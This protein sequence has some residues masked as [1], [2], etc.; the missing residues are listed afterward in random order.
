MGIPV[1]DILDIAN[2][3][4]EHLGRFHWTDIASDLQ[5]Y[6]AMKK[7]LR[8]E[9]IVFDSG[10]SIRRNFQT[11][12]NGSARMTEL[13]DQDVTPIPDTMTKNSIPWRN[14]QASYGFDEREIAMNATPAK[15][16]DLLQTRRT[17]EML[18][19]A[20][21]LESQMWGQPDDS[22]DVKSLWGVPFWI[23]H[24][25]TEGFNGGY[26]SGFTDLA[27]LD[28]TVTTRF[29]NWTAAFTNVT[30]DD[31]IDSWR[32]GYDKMQFRC[33]VD[34]P[35]YKRGEDRYIFYMNL[36][37]KKEIETIGEKQNDSLGKDIASMDGQIVFRGNPLVWVPQLDS[38][39][40]TSSA[41]SWAPKN[42]IYCVNWSVFFVAF[43]R[44]FYMKESGIRQNPVSHN[45][46][47]S[48]LDNTFNF[49]C[50]NRRRQGV[51]YQ[52]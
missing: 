52:L 45:V 32:L 13:F 44:G 39:D 43:L 24:N 33:P 50:D 6:H 42:P 23:V 3:G 15:I 7:I 22:T 16:V 12:D 5:E 35:E 25:A 38:F 37:T 40:G 8:K 10:H 1:S 36:A 9:R 26:P 47:E 49:V 48:F 34:I 20:R 31:L 28:L 19:L 14:A 18:S 41:P 4:L 2:T 51:M 27:G 17:A 46:F 11:D 21:L 30:K 29:K